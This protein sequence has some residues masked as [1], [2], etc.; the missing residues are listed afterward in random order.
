L[1]EAAILSSLK[2]PRV[3]AFVA[4]FQSPTE[5]VIVTEYLSGGELF[6]RVASEQT[7]E[8]TEADCVA[9][10]RQICEGVAYLHERVSVKSRHT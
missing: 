3:V 5:V 7:G 6:E 8:V 1:E 9:Y 2:C 4:A 10:M